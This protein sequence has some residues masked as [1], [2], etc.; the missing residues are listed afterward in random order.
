MQLKL[1][2][3]CLLLSV[4]ATFAVV[5][6]PRG[7][8]TLA[9]SDIAPDGF[10]RSASLIN[11]IHPGPV[12]TANMGDDI[13][14]NV[15][16]DLTDEHQILGASIHWHGLFQRNTNF[17]DGVVDVTQCPIA[18]NNSFEYSFSTKGQSGTYWYHSHFDV[19]YCDGVRGALIIYDPNDPLKSMYDVDD[20]STIISLSDWYHTLASDI[21]GIEMEDATLINGLGRYVGGPKVDLAVINVAQFK[22]YRFR[23]ISMACSP[24]YI[25]SIDQHDLTIIETEGTETAPVTVNSIQILAGQRYS[26]VLKANQ[27][28]DNYWIRALPNLGTNGLSKTFDGGVNSAILRYKGARFAEPRTQQQKQTIPLIE[29]NLHPANPTPVPGGRSPDGAD[30][31]F[32]FTL[33]LN[34][35]DPDH[36]RWSFN[37][38]PFV[39]PSVPVLLQILSGTTDPAELVPEGTIYRVERNK[40]IQ[41]NIPTGLVG[42]PHP[43][44]LHGH[45]F[46][47]VKSADSSE[48]NF[49][50]PV[51]R[52]TVS[53]GVN[54]GDY[55]SIRFRTDNPGPW[56]LHCHIDFHLRDGLAIV[57]AE[58]PEETESFNSPRPDAWDQLCPIWDDQ[59]D[60]VKNA[61][62]NN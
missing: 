51:I 5:I 21:R 15:V 30:Q 2:F 23:I 8:I 53:A 56:I 45:E 9:N 1:N 6:G 24:D 47:V 18:P 28:I 34:T 42:G 44:H 59:P 38:T 37:N 3:A 43:F 57:F 7:T 27:T 61:G 35:T 4:T 12:I 49:N 54:E 26:A 14:I 16:N 25:F 22:R 33:Q 32:T 31:T 48:Y 50:D 40:T 46:W 13:K 52:D 55:V 41:L 19:Q 29:A 20:E 39:A 60:S 36:V 58:A 10:T 17:M 62:H 11:G